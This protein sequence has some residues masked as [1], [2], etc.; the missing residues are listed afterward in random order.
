MSIGLRPSPPSPGGTVLAARRET[1][2]GAPVER[3][4]R[5]PLSVDGLVAAS[6]TY[7]A[8]PYGIFLLGWLRP[9]IGLPLLALLALAAVRSG[10]AAVPLRRPAV[11][12]T[13]A[14]VACGLLGLTALWVLLSGVGGYWHQNGD[15]EKHNAVLHDLVHQSW[16]VYYDGGAGRVVLVYYF[17]FYLPAAVVGKLAGWA[18]ANH[19]LFGWTLAG[20]YLSVIWFARLVGGRRP[21]AALVF[22]L[23]SGLDV[24]AYRAF[25]GQ[26]PGPVEHIEVWAG[27]VLQYSSHTTLLFWTPQHAIAGWIGA[28]LVL[29]AAG[30]TGRVR[31]LGCLLALTALW[32]PLVTLGLLPLAALALWQAR[33]RGSL[34]AENLI[35]APLLLAPTAAFYLSSTAEVPRDW[36]WR[37]V[38][39]RE[40]WPKLLAFYLLEF[41]IYALLVAGQRR[42]DGGPGRRWLAVCAGVLLLLPL[43][44]Y[45]ENNDF[46]M[47]TAIP[48]LFVVAVSVARALRQATGLRGPRQGLALLLVIGACTPGLEI[49]RAVQQRAKGPQGTRRVLDHAKPELVQQ[50]LGSPDS[51]FFTTLARDMPKATGAPTA[52]GTPGA[53]AAPGAS[54]FPLGGAGL[55]VVPIGSPTQPPAAQLRWLAG[56][57]FR[58]GWYDGAGRLI[59]DPGPDGQPRPRHGAA[60][61][62][63]PHML[64]QVGVGPGATPEDAAGAGPAMPDY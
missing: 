63:P 34:T 21:V 16:P 13:G 26:W 20:A 64:G 41:G 11:S 54:P 51:P 36:L 15:F 4:A 5:V 32:S 25:K 27:G 33:L 37:T 23:F 62:L 9:V 10:R 44:R 43:Y 57:G 22:M 46:V 29:H 48:A 30:G 3:P 42:D 14:I 24:V 49:S 39:P 45:G 50:Y 61:Y 55:P 28:A 2:V 1:P 7:L 19:A 60:E 6:A 8:I 40:F 35:L 58:D 18:A 56:S 17:G 12:P 31:G 52:P 38:D 53:P 59:Y 47:R